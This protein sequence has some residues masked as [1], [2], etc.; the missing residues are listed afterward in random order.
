MPSVSVFEPSACLRP[1]VKCYW[2]LKST[3]HDGIAERKHLLSDSGMKISFNLADQVEYN[4]KGSGLFSVPKA[5]LSGPSTHNFWLQASGRLD[6]IGIQFRPGGAYPFI[7]T[8]A[9]KLRDRFIELEAILGNSGRLLMKRIQN[10]GQTTKDRI[11]ILERFLLKRF[12]RPIHF[13]SAFDFAINTILAYR[14]QMAIETLSKGMHIS[15]R[16]LD[17]KFKYKIGIPPKLFCRIIRFRHIFDYISKYPGTGWVSVAADCGYYD[18][19]HLIRDFNIFSGSSPINF[20][21]KIVN[22]G[23]LIGWGL[24]YTPRESEEF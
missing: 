24:N 16:T 8:P 13:D 1:Y 15:N 2:T 9:Y 20:I 3:E 21:N 23:L 22:D 5:C 17:R 10:P 12:E 18:Q 7:S 14:G 19:S 11:Q 6:R 4:I